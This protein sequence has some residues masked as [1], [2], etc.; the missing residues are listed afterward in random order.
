MS[1]RCEKHRQTMRK[2]GIAWF[3]ILLVSLPQ[4]GTIHISVPR[5]VAWLCP[6]RGLRPIHNIPRG[7]GYLRD[8]DRGAQSASK[9]NETYNLYSIFQRLIL[10][11][12]CG[13][14]VSSHFLCPKSKIRSYCSP[15]DHQ[16]RTTR[17][18]SLQKKFVCE[19][20]M[21]GD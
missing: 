21:P 11:T 18:Q 17:A 16:H 15:T 8:K 14:P 2:H 4:E 20:E 12:F 7:G 5:C 10:H 13:L 3:P 6:I 19:F 9:Q 1:S